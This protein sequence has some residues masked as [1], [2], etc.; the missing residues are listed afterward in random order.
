MIFVY[1]AMLETHD[2]RQKMSDLYAT[3]REYLLRIA[4]T[5]LHS[6]ADAVDVL[7]QAFVRIARDFS[8]IGEIPSDQT[9]NFLVITVRGLALDL[10]DRRRKV[11]EV[12]FSDLDQSEDA[13]AVE[14]DVLEQLEY[15]A[16]RH[17]LELLPRM[18][19][20][21]LY[22]RYYSELSVKEIAGFT[23]LSES[24]VKKR[25]ERARYALQGAI[26][27]ERMAAA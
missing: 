13:F 25:L 16:L 3:Y 1:M 21:M 24:A 4:L 8:K 26:R 2:D 27:T 7:H 20:D 15:E 12:S 19:R 11:I 23:R 14:D 6:Q 18:H 5:I 10:I 17:T 22:Y 9:R